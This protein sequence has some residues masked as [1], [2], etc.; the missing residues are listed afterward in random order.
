MKRHYKEPIGFT[1]IWQSMKPYE[2][3]ELSDRLGSPI[4]SLGHVSQ[5]FKK[6]SPERA[7]A[8]IRELRV[9]GFK[10]DRH[11]LRPDIW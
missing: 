5:R 3:R 6:P 7:D 8:I 10:V 2:K 4:A 9:M 11:D 1:I